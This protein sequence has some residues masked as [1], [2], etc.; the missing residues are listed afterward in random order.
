MRSR[1]T[2]ICASWVNDPTKLKKMVP[3]AEQARVVDNFNYTKPFS[4]YPSCYNQEG[5]CRNLTL[6][7][8][9]V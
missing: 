4:A 1:E 7:R 8:P 5:D 2:R 6:S 3:L 9:V